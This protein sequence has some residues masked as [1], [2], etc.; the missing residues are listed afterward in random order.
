[1]SPET[2]LA[3][4]Q[5]LIESKDS[6]MKTNYLADGQT[7]VFANLAERL[8]DNNMDLVN[9]KYLGFVVSMLSA[10]KDNHEVREIALRSNEANIS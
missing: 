1:M 2:Y 7:A 8:Q 4:R 3:V 6:A 5:T 10:M 9:Q